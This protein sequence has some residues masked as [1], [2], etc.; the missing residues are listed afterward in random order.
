MCLC[1][2]ANLKGKYHWSW[3]GNVWKSRTFLMRHS[4][5]SWVL[6]TALGISRPVR[7]LTK[8]ETEAQMQRKAA[9]IVITST[10]VLCIKYSVYLIASTF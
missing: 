5:W 1:V 2:C 10:S 3:N 7:G 9:N 8:E 4:L 6:G